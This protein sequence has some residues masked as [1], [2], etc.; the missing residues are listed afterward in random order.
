M[1]AGPAMFRDGSR[2][3]SST[4]VTRGFVR[5]FV[6]GASYVRVAGFEGVVVGCLCHGL[7]CHLSS[8][9]MGGRHAGGCFRWILVSSVLFLHFL[10]AS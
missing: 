7:L 9:A 2:W 6:R 10:C 5:M 3:L 1:A 4:A 8:G